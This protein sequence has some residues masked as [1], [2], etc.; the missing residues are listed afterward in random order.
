MGTRDSQREE[1][2]EE[3][4]GRRLQVGLGPLPSTDLRSDTRRLERIHQSLD[5]GM[6]EERR[7]LHK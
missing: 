3:A 7:N 5:V 4:G 1:G 2:R 6:I